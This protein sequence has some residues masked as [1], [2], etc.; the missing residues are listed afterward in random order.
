MIYGL[1]L[2]RIRFGAINIVQSLN[3]VKERFLGRVIRCS[4]ALGS[5]EHD[6]F[7]IVGQSGV[8]S[9]IVLSS[10]PDSYQGLEAGFFLIDSHIDFQA[11]LKSIDFRV[12]RVALE[13]LVLS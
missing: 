8:V 6:M 5:L 9:R 4:E 1:A 11:I 3:L 12:H 10:V 7:Q 2:L 13:S